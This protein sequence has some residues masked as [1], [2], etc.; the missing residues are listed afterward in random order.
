VD[1]NAGQCYAFT[2]T[3]LDDDIYV[4]AQCSTIQEAVDNSWDGRTVWVADGIYTGPDNRNIDFKRKRITVRSENGPGNCIIDCNGIGR[5]FYFHNREGPLSIL[6]GL[7]ITN[8]AKGGAAIYCDNR[9][10][11]VITNC[12]IA[13][14]RGDGI[15]CQ[16]ESRPTI[17][18]CLVAGNGG[19][20]IEAWGI[21]S[22]TI[23]NCTIVQNGAAGIYSP[24][25]R[26]KI[27]SCISWANELDAIYGVAPYV[28][29]SN[30]E[31]GYP[32]EGNIDADPCFVSMGYWVDVNDPNIIV[33]PEDPNAVWVEGDYHLLPDSPCI[34]AGDPGFVPE[35]NETC[36]GGLPRVMNGRVDM[37]AYEFNHIPDIPVAAAMMFT[38][39]MLNCNSKVKWVKANFV[40]PAG[41]WPVDVDVRAPAVAKPV[42]LGSEGEIE[43]EYIKVVG[44]EH[45]SVRV[46]AAFDRQ[47]FCSMVTDT[48]RAS[49]EVKVVGFFVTGQ[50][51]YGTNTVRMINLR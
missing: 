7:T 47:T 21:E 49:L 28:S 44:N 8:G 14:N 10:N 37:G 41:F 3:S 23:T 24:Y 36:V 1:D 4:P 31:G 26:P 6:S 34:D 12:T 13:G 42:G 15:Y 51:F 9:T 16:H 27:I 39:Q 30:I 22:A 25:G 17:A 33:G 11:P 18:N 45:G 2:T 46:E 29:Y 48:S 38:P 20:G 32:G 43:S 19:V 50:Y 35:P 40:L 5:G